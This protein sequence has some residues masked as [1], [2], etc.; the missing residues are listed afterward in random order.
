MFLFVDTDLKVDLPQAQVVVDREKVADLKLDLA[1]IAGELGVLLGGGYVNRFNYFNRS[2]QVIPQLAEEDRQSASSLMD[3]KIR[4]PSGQLIPVS[5][6]AT[7]LPK[8]AP[9][10]LSRFQQQSAIQIQ[11]AVMPGVPGLTK[12]AG[13]RKIEQEFTRRRGAM[14][15]AVKARK[16][17]EEP[18]AESRAAEEPTAASRTAATPKAAMKVPGKHEILAEA[19]AMKAQWLHTV[20]GASALVER[21]NDPSVADWRWASNEF[22]ARMESVLVAVN[23]A[24]TFFHQRVPRRR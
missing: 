8:T 1:S 18:V 4:T 10:V 7:I 12:E 16:R 11:A 3:L 2:Y 23:A 19:E 13:L 17:G 6:F 9:R 5:T 21:I 22:K 14:A 15:S 24:Q 20:S